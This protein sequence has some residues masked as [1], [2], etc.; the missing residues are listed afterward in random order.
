VALQKIVEMFN[1]NDQSSIEKFLSMNDNKS[2]TH[3][4]KL[5][6]TIVSSKMSM[7]L[8][9]AFPDKT[10]SSFEYS[11]DILKSKTDIWSS[12]T[13]TLIN[14]NTY[15]GIL[16]A[17]DIEKKKFTFLSNQD[18]LISGKLSKE[19]CSYEF[20]VPSNARVGIEEHAKTEGLSKKKTVKYILSEILVSSEN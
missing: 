8:E 17:V 13:E 9:V 16:K 7:T 15:N 2:T 6:K 14:L 3:F 11:N 10:Y 4:K 19:V 18:E 20:V 12:D 5:M 1:I